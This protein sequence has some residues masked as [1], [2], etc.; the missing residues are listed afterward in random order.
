ML[1]LKFNFIGQIL[2]VSLPYETDIVHRHRWRIGLKSFRIDEALENLVEEIG[3]FVQVNIDK[4]ISRT[5]M[6][7]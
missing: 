2:G 3:G 7:R 1:M 4:I 5:K 6:N